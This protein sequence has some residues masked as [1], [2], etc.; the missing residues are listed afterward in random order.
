MA[1]RFILGRSGTGKTTHC[2]EAVAQA[3]REPSGPSLLFLVPEQATY[4]AERAILSSG[5]A[6]YHRLRVLSFN[7][8]QFFLTGPAAG[9]TVSSI[10]RQMIVHKVLR[11]CRERLLLFRSTALLP[12]FARQIAETIREL[13]RYDMTCEDLDALQANRTKH[14]SPLPA[15]KFADLALVFREYTESIRGRFVDP[16]ARASLACKRIA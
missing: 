14:A 4:E 5:P 13:H 6:G 7:R 9:R 10:G 15:M 1:V 12:G 16:D 11:D 3:L 2:V 8:L